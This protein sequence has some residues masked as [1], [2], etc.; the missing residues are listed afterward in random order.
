MTTTDITGTCARCREEF[1]G[2]QLFS[3]GHRRFLCSPCETAENDEVR[4]RAELAEGNR[5]AIER[6]IIEHLPHPIKGAPHLAVCSCGETF[7][8]LPAEATAF[9]VWAA[10]LAGLLASGEHA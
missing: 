8:A 2:N 6:R 10:H 9:K 7:R 5:E 1:P 3:A 4:Q